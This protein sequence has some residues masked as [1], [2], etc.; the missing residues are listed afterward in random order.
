M[1]VKPILNGRRIWTRLIRRKEHLEFMI[2]LQVRK[3]G[4]NQMELYAYK[5]D[6]SIVL[7]KTTIDERYLDD[8]EEFAFWHNHIS[9]IR[10]FNS[11][12][13][14]NGGD[15]DGLNCGYMSLSKKEL[16]KLAEKL[17]MA[18]TEENKRK[19]KM[20]CMDALEVFKEGKAVIISAWW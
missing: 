13:Y 5:V 3:G 20:F 19:D 6:P 7:S 8:L 12:W 11:M 4:D 9:L 2:G 18:K 10:Y 15:K 14:R 17:P 1:Y 16:Y